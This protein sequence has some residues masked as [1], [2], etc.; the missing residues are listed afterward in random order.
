MFVKETVPGFLM[1]N[2][3]ESLNSFFQKG[4]ITDV[5]IMK[6]LTDIKLH[7]LGMRATFIDKWRT[8]VP[9]KKV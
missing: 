6:G 3:L 2:G 1:K 5:E 8:V 4:L 9:Y 7:K